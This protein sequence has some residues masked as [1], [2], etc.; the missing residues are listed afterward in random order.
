MPSKHS[1]IQIQHDDA[2]RILNFNQDFPRERSIQKPGKRVEHLVETLQN[3][4]FVFQL[5]LQTKNHQ[6]LNSAIGITCTKGKNNTEMSYEN[7]GTN[8]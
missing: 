2:D 1:V 6:T 3:F 4:F 8:K 5:A 7:K